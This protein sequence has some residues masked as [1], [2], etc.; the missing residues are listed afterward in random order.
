MSK[1]TEDLVEREPR[2]PEHEH[3][4]QPNGTV[5]DDRLILSPASVYDH[6]KQQMT[7]AVQSCECGAV[8][9]VRIGVE[10]ARFV[11]R[12]ARGVTVA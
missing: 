1:S 6:M 4:W 5:V 9:K 12:G 7:Y 2:E 10:A 11:N 3:R 8:R